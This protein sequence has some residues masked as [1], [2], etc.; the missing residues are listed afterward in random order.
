MA[1]AGG[2]VHDAALGEQVQ[3]P[4]VG[5]LVLLHQRQHLAPAAD[6]ERTQVLEV[7][8]DVEVPGVGQHRAVLHP[9]EVLARAAHRARR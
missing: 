1:L 5:E 8:L 6:R 7:D 4:P 9:L 2:Q 3:A